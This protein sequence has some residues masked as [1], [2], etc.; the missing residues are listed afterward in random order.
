MI[1]KVIYKNHLNEVF[2]FGENGVY[3]NQND[4]RNYEWSYNE[5]N[6]KISNF[7][8]GIA[9]KTIPVVVATPNDVTAINTLME[10]CEKDVL[11]NVPGSLIIGEYTLN[12]FIVSS[13]KSRYILHKGYS[14]IELGVV[15]DTPAWIKSTISTFNNTGAEEGKDLDFTFDFPYDFTSP[16]KIKSVINPSFA[17]VDFKLNIYG[18]VDNPSVTIGGHEYKVN[19]RVNANEYLTINSKDKTIYITR[20]NG[21]IV[22]HFKDRSKDT[23]IFNKIPSGELKVSWNGNFGFDITLFEERSEPKWI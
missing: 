5:D 6:N 16:N 11:S 8:R 21:E 20:N 22:N 13:R 9:K 12:C 4:L 10:V 3:I 7:K 1:E 18:E 2:K 19:C 14:N 23:Y 15:T 17:D